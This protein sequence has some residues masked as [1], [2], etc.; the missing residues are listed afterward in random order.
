[1]K[2]LKLTTPE[3]PSLFALEKIDAI[4][5]CDPKRGSNDTVVNTRIYMTG[6]QDYYNVLETT[7]EIAKILPN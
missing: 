1:M 2:F 6:D 7:K 4:V 3:G 5:A